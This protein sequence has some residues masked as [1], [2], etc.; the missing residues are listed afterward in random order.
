VRRAKPEHDSLQRCGSRRPARNPRRPR[1]RCGWKITTV[2]LP[3]PLPPRHRASPLLLATET[4]Q[5]V[6]REYA[7]GDLDRAPP[8]RDR[9]E[10]PAR[11]A[12][13]RR[14]RA[15]LLTQRLAR[16]DDRRAVEERGSERADF[17]GVPRHAV[18]AQRA[19]REVEKRALR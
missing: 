18:P 3:L 16:G 1:R 2:R 12:R 9:R 10:A 19:L 8:E 13:R 5:R 4:L 15:V 17:G 6:G 11:V 14:Q 7:E